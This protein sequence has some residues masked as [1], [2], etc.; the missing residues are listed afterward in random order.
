MGIHG[1][2]IYQSTNT[3]FFSTQQVELAV[4]THLLQLIHKPLN[5]ALDSASAGRLFPATETTL[6]LSSRFIIPTLLQDLEQLVKT[7]TYPLF[8]A[9]TQASSNLPGFIVEGNNQA[10]ALTCSTFTSPRRKLGKGM[11]L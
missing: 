2:D 1:L 3:F 4:L 9:H 8:I 7:H 6:I 10:D 11:H 5:I